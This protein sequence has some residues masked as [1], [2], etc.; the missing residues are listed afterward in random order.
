MHEPTVGAAHS[1]SPRIESIA[2]RLGAL[3]GSTPRIG[4]DGL[5]T[6]IEVDLPDKLSNAA[7]HSLLVALADADRCGHEVADGYVWAEIRELP[8][9]ARLTAEQRAGYECALC[10]MRLYASRCLG[11]VNGVQLWACAPAC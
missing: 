6:R 3:T 2:A 9:P 4:A 11:T 1:R 8:D 10:G 7:R 5:S